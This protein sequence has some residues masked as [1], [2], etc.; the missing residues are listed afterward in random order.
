MDCI[1]SGLVNF[2]L[3]AWGGRISEWELTEKSGHL[4]L[5][6]QGDLIL[7]DRGFDIQESVTFKR[8]LVNVL[9]RLESRQKQMPAHEVERTR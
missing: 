8:I 7:A 3:Y 6:E 1:P 4:D 5:L 2:V 9:P